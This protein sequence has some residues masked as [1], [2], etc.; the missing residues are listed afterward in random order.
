M[1][2]QPLTSNPFLSSMPALFVQEAEASQQCQLFH[3]VVIDGIPNE[4]PLYLVDSNYDVTYTSLVGDVPTAQT[5]LRFPLKF[6][7]VSVS[8]DGSIDKASITVSNVARSLMQHVE[9]YDGLSGCSVSVL[10]VYAKFLDFIYSYSIDGELSITPNPEK[11][12]KACIRDEFVIDSY[13][14][15]EQTIAFQLNALVD[16]EIKVPRRRYT[17][18]SC[19]WKFKDP[20]TCGYVSHVDNST[21][22]QNFCKKT[23]QA[24]KEHTRVGID[25]TKGNSARYGGFPGI[26]S[27]IRRLFSS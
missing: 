27:D 7:G 12:Y 17:P 10:T 8:T 14:A 2:R 6:S 11:D 22:I 19:Y 3:L 18:F 16:F 5:Y 20:D 23:L 13:S 21:E 4:A 26:P 24:C 1:P 15:N 25:P 9:D